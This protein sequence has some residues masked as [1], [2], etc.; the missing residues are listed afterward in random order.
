MSIST[1]VLMH[2]LNDEDIQELERALQD[3]KFSV[4]DIL[5]LGIESLKP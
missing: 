1:N 3:G 2:Y 5:L 4:T